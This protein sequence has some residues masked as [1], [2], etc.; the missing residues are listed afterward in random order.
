MGK[1]SGRGIVLVLAG[2]LLF[3]SGWLLGQQSRTPQRSL[4]HVF[5]FAP[6][7]GA[8]TKD[9]A[10]FKK[11]T[12][13]MVGKIP[14]LRKVW[15]GELRRPIYSGGQ[16]LMY[17]VAMEFDDAKALDGYARNPVHTAWESV[18]EKVRVEGTTTF[19]ILGE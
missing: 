13:D 5:A 8:T 9:Y 2:V 12:A 11:A 14:G 4:L 18:Y 17:G 1:L 16:S 7:D 6:L 15:V 10:A 19:D 3:G